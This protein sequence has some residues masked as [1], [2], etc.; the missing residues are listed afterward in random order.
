MLQH[1]S[2]VEIFIRQKKSDSNEKFLCNSYG[3]D[4]YLLFSKDY[5]DF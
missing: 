2:I 3:Y 1:R 4:I 5:V